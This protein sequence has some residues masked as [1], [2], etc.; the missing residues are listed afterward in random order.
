MLV[1]LKCECLT[2]RMGS[3]GVLCMEILRTQK[4]P[5]PPNDDTYHVCLKDMSLITMKLVPLP[6]H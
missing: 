2:H 3:Y 5:P 6:I 1:H 4:L